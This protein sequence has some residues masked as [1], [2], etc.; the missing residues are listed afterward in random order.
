MNFWQ[1]TATVVGLIGGTASAIWLGIHYG[2][3]W[4]DRML[5]VP[6]LDPNKPIVLPVPPA[7]EP[8]EW[9]KEIYGDYLQSEEGRRLYGDSSCP[10]E[11]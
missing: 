4:V 1:S 8:P 11:K 3:K 10:Q 5:C 9:F 2:S 6:P 7:S